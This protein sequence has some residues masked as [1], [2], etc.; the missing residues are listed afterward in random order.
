MNVEGTAKCKLWHLCKTRNKII[1][2]YVN[3]PIIAAG[4]G[5]SV[6]FY[7]KCYL[8]VKKREREKFHGHKN[9]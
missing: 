7:A 9:Q 2:A 1:F 3:K 4:I 8:N 6:I 5:Y